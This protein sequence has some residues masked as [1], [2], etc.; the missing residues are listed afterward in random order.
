FFNHKPDF[1]GQ[2]TFFDVNVYRRLCNIFNTHDKNPSVFR[3]NVITDDAD[4]N[5][6]IGQEF[7]LQGVKFLGTEECAPCYWMN[8][9]FHEGAEQA[10]KGHGGLRAKILSDGSVR[11]NY[12]AD[13]AA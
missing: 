13:T 4:L 10:L 6:L 2:I 12:P 1:K 5:E 11:A 8:Q 9:A 3:R 7:E